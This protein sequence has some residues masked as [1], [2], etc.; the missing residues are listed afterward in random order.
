MATRGS[1][2]VSASTSCGAAERTVVLVTGH[3]GPGTLNVLQ[4][5]HDG[6]AVTVWTKKKGNK[7]S[8]EDVETFNAQYRPLKLRHTEAFLNL[9]SWHG[10]ALHC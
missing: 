10:I 3:V 2:L 1:K 9:T 5:K 8:A 4:K 6:V 7:L